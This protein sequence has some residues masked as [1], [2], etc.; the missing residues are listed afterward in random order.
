MHPTFSVYSLCDLRQDLF[1]YF[2]HSF[3]DVRGGLLKKPKILIAVA[4][5]YS[6]SRAFESFLKEEGYNV[7]V[8][9]RNMANKFSFWNY[10]REIMSWKP[11][12]VHVINDPE[13]L[14]LPVIFASKF[15]GAKIIYDKRANCSLERK[16]LRRDMFYYVERFAEKVGQKFYVSKITPIFRLSKNEKYV[17]IPQCMLL[18]DVQKHTSRKKKQVVLTGGTL[19]VARDI[20]AVITS[21]R[22]IKRKDVEF[23][24]FGDGLARKYAEKAKKK[25]SRIR[26]FARIPYLEYLSKVQ[27]ADVCIIP[28]S[29]L[30]STEYASPYSV[31]KMGEFTFF[32]KPT[33]CADIGDMRIAEKNGLLFYTPGDSKDLAKKIMMQLKR[34]KK[35]T[36]FA[37]LE[38]SRVKK[39]YI[40][41][42]RD[43]IA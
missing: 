15:V 27:S 36:F 14:V 17:L 3:N 7:R 24:I 41:I 32:N 10:F 13:F 42:V 22:Q 43:L 4:A 18:K 39:S 34:P 16:E 40:K 26:I 5:H 20:R 23:W 1:L 28:F 8:V 2:I 38:Q 9:T 19:S 25:D 12:I 21:F 30:A 6:R 29:R 33:I 31:L 11:Q 37:E 35:T